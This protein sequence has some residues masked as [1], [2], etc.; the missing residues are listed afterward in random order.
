MR[1]N[2]DTKPMSQSDVESKV[3]ALRQEAN[4]EQCDINELKARLPRN[5]RDCPKAILQ[6]SMAYGD[7]SDEI[8]SIIESKMNDSNGNGN[9]TDTSLENVIDPLKK[10]RKDMDKNRTRNLFKEIRQFP[11]NQIDV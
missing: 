11:D 3:A 1:R 4:P 7:N 6:Q 2:Q 8:A 9:P 5:L 10:L